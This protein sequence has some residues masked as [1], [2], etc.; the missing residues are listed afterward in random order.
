MDRPV[1]T[2]IW[3]VQK[4]TNLSRNEVKTLKE[5]S[6]VFNKQPILP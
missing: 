6:F 4:G 1:V 5:A 2:L 3:H